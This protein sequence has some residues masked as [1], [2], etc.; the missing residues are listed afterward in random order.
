MQKL[1]HSDEH[2]SGTSR[3]SACW[4]SAALLLALMNRA[5]A[6]FIAAVRPLIIPALR[7]WSAAVF[8]PTENHEVIAAP[9]AVNAPA[10]AATGL[11]AMSSFPTRI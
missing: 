3:C 10:N 5:A 4:P 8:P 1:L 7:P 9:F 6:L 11:S 2:L